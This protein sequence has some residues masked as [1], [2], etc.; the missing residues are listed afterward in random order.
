MIKYS[1]NLEETCKFDILIYAVSSIYVRV[2]TESLKEYINPTQIIVGVAKGIENDT[3]YT[4]SSVIC[5]VYPN[6]K[7][8][9]LSGPTHAEEV[10]MNLPLQLSR[11]AMI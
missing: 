11:L 3:L 2:T 8:V 5:S 9:E 7:V 10:A 6:N 1:S 4:M